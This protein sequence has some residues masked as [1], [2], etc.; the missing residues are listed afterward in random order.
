MPNY[1]LIVIGAGI[2]GMTAA[3]SAAKSGIKKIL[4]LIMRK[5]KNGKEIFTI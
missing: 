4:I 3:L 2:A 5:N 1:D